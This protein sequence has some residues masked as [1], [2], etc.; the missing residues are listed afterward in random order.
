MSKGASGLYTGTI[1]GERQ[2]LRKLERL[3]SKLDSDEPTAVVWSHLNATAENYGGTVIP[4]SF[5]IDVPITSTTPNGRMWTHGNATEHMYEAVS[6]IKA[7]APRIINSNPNLYSQFILYD[8]YK[9]LG[10]AL[11]KGLPYGKRT[12]IGNWEFII[13]Q[14][15]NGGRFPVVKHALFTGL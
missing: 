5:E 11:K 12:T 2:F 1:G 14:P 7:Q 4:R 8:Y 13:A 10:K 15:R 6:T 3:F 9:S